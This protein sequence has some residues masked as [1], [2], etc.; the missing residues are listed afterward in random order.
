MPEKHD[1]IEI[2]ELTGRQAALYGSLVAEYA[3]S[4]S[5]AEGQAS[6]EQQLA[7]TKCMFMQLRK[8]A[9]HPLLVRSLYTDDI[10]RKMAKALKKVRYSSLGFGCGM[11]GLVAKM[12]RDIVAWFSIP[13]G[14]SL[15][16]E[17]THKAIELD[18]IFEDLAV[19]NDFQLHCMCKQHRVR[20]SL[21]SRKTMYSLVFFH[22][23]H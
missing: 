22:F 5:R 19:L 7:D 3:A 20:G 10:L 11:E 13:D 2:C 1:R 16:Q 9:N 23:R 14:V 12:T 18:L 4:V 6:G 8:V 17:K 15:L 21:S